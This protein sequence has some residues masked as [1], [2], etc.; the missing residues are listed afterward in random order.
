LRGRIADFILHDN[1]FG[2]D[3]SPEAVEI[4]QLSLWLRSAQRGKTLADLSKNIVCG[5]SLVTDTAVDPLAM[6]WQA[7]FPEVFSARA[8]RL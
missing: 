7:T 8:V 3:L 4:T 1:L 5:N 2:V 6:N